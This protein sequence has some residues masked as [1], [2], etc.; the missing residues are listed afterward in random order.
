LNEATKR[1]SGTISDAAIR[2]LILIV[3]LQLRLNR[4]S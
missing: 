4:S 1:P 3:A 2:I